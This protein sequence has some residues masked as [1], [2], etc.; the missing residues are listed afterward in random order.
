MSGETKAIAIE[1]GDTLSNDIDELLGLYRR[2]AFD[3]DLTKRTA[4]SEQLGEPLALVMVDLDKFKAIND[5]HGHPAGDEVLQSV[6]TTIKKTVGKKGES[7]R[8]GG[9]ELSILLPN[10]TADEAASLAERIRHQIETSR[11][12]SKSLCV[13]ASFGVAETPTHAKTAAELLKAADS[14]LYESKDLGRNLVRISGESRPVTPM[15]RVTARKQPDP[16]SLTEKEVEKIRAA[17]FRYHSAYCPRDGSSLRIQELGSDEQVT[18]HLLISC[19]F[20]GVSER[21]EGPS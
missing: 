16:S 10:Y 7:Y 15:P 12:G 6:A 21:L 5:A 20:C 18:P 4:L 8:Y 17:Y 2:G 19:P 14:A 11:I 3:R 1:L 9:E 13:T